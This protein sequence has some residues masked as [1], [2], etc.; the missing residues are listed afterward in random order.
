MCSSVPSA[1]DACGVCIC[2]C[3]MVRPAAYTAACRRGAHREE[4]PGLST[5]RCTMCGAPWH[6]KTALESSVERSARKAAYRR[7]KQEERRHADHQRGIARATAIEVTG[8]AVVLCSVTL[9]TA[10]QPAVL[11]CQRQRC[12]GDTGDVRHVPPA[13]RGAAAHTAP[14]QELVGWRSSG[15]HRH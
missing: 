15:R 5:A 8:R 6:H 1:R 2:N 14:V 13:G 11:E 9:E 4:L 7:G 3:V 10:L 12:N